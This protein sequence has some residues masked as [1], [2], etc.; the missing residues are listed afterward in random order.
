[1]TC[2]HANGMSPAAWS[3]CPC[4][5]IGPTGPA[6]MPGPPG[7]AGEPGPPGVQG[8]QG[9]A[10]PAGDRGATGPTGPAGAQGIPGPT[11]PTGPAGSASVIGPT[12]PTG[13]AGQTGP[14]GPAGE[15]GAPGPT[16][17]AGSQGPA[18]PTGPAGEAG[19]TGPTGS[20][21]AIGPTGPAGETGPTGPAGETGPTGPAG[22]TGPTGPAGTPAEDVFASFYNPSAV[23][24]QGNYLELYPDVTDPTGQITIAGNQRIQLAAGHYLVICKISAIFRTANYMQITPAYNGAPHLEYGIYFATST[25]GSSAAGSANFIIRAPA[26]TELTFSYN[27][28]GSATDGEINVTVLKLNRPL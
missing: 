23:L 15:Q 25:N 27:S 7:P 8:I 16:G 10:G 17:S 26:A 13:P 1:M 3:G 6:G 9:P 4:C 21:G 12:G 24:N 18:G 28:S 20:A 5:R 2:Y 11:G 19:P 22:E 14:T